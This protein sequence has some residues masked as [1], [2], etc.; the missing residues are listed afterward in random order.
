VNGC[1]HPWQVFL[2]NADAWLCIHMITICGAVVILLLS[3]LH[4]IHDVLYWLDLEQVQPGEA[5]GP[6]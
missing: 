6:F 3:T 4:E 5:C 2:Q 1:N